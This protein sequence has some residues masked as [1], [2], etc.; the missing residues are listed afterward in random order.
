MN[1]QPKNK[2]IRC[3]K[4]GCFFNSYYRRC[5]KCG[6][7]R[8]VVSNEDNDLITAEDVWKEIAQLY[9]KLGNKLDELN[10]MLK[11]G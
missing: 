10:R 5:W 3:E 11:N 6:C 4:C 1:P 7:K 2:R 9:T 8:P